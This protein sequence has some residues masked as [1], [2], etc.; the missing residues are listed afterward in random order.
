MYNDIKQGNEGS[1]TIIH[2]DLFS[3]NFTVDKSNNKKKSADHVKE[4]DT[5]RWSAV[6][7]G[8]REPGF[9][10]GET[11]GNKCVW[12]GIMVGG[13]LKEVCLD[14]MV[15]GGGQFIEN[16]SKIYIANI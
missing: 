7:E 1:L 10:R 16:H 4:M 15:E 8:T 5:V 11:G 9:K 3:V 2:S 6:K 12:R 13:N 14:R